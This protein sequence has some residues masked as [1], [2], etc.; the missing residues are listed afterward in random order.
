MASAHFTFCVDTPDSVKAQLTKLKEGKS[1]AGGGKK[2]WGESAADLGVME[3][4]H[5]LRFRKA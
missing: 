1:T 2:F 4:R 5:G 3:D